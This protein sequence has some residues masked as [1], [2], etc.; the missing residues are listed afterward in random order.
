MQY[1]IFEEI[2]FYRMD[3]GREAKVQIFLLMGGS[4][5]DF[6]FGVSPTE[7]APPQRRH[8]V[9]TR[10]DKDVQRVRTVS[11]RRLNWKSRLTAMIGLGDFNIFEL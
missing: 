5:W 4:N 1:H 9:Q 8:R 10:T 6:R 11:G 7:Y 3:E 2:V